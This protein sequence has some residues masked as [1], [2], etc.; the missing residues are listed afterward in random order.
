MKLLIADDALV[1]R[2]VVSKVAA[3]AGY[4]VH[5]VA[6]G[7][8]LVAAYAESTPDAVLVDW[9]MPVLDGIDAIRRIRRLPDGDRSFIIVITGQS[10]AE[11]TAA[12]LEAGADDYLVKPISVPR[13]QVLL[14]LTEARVAGRLAE[15][16]AARP[17][18]AG[19][20]P[21]AADLLATFGR[22]LGVDTLGKISFATCAVDGRTREQLVGRDADSVLGTAGEAF[23]DWSRRAQQ[24]DG[25]TELSTALS[26]HPWTVKAVWRDGRLLGF[27]LHTESSSA[28]RL[29][30]CRPNVAVEGK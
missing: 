23:A 13:L 14:T 21:A 24:S 27:A 9:E 2:M 20:E 18:S 26:D 5:A 29:D 22:V 30:G 28:L 19:P 12:A 4:D 8:A 3:A 10:T 7:E 25:P 15:V 16:T 11:Q 17:P 1:T 6:D